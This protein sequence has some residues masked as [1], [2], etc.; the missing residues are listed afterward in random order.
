[1]PASDRPPRLPSVSIVV[2]TYNERESLASL[3]D[4]V[5]AVWRAAGIEGEIIV[6][7]DAS[8][9]GTGDE[10][11][12]LT[13][14]YPVQVVHRPA[15]LGLGSA[16]IAGFGVARHE[17]MGVMDG[18]FS[19]PP[20]KIVDL[21]APFTDERIDFVIGSRYVAGGGT[22]RWSPARL[23]LSRLACWL[24][25]PLTPVR[26][27]SSGFF[28]VRRNVPENVEIKAGGFKICLELL[29]RG[30]ARL[31]TEVPYVFAGRTTGTS[32]LNMLEALGYLR[33]LVDLFRYQR[34]DR[35]GRTPAYRPP[36]PTI[37]GMVA[38]TPAAGRPRPS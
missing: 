26:D 16:V 22:E 19:H 15:K 33:Q 8:P 12:R 4:E 5:V 21:L 11:E 23:W 31:V 20:A 35:R 25:R 38:D 30:R 32:K 24:S 27:A 6:V 3:V 37:P 18:D 36:S 1:M 10:A 2:P 29:V 7:D 17:I 34:F 9:D 13:A 28:L 14:S